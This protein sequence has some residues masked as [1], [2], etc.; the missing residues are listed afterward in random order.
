MTLNLVGR[1]EFK[2]L[3]D[4]AIKATAADNAFVSLSDRSG[5]TTRFANSQITQNVNVRRQSLSV[6]VAFGQ[7]HGS[8][9]TTQLSDAAIQETVRRA[10]AVAKIA[11]EDAEYL[12]P[13]PAQHYPVLPTLRLETAETGPA[14]RLRDAKTAIDLCRA[15]DLTAAGIVSTYTTATGLAANTGLFAHE[16]RSRAQFSLTATGKNSTGWVNNANRSID[17]LGVEQRTRNA[18]DKA[19]GSADPKEIP[20]GKYTV[21]ATFAPTS[22]LSNSRDSIL[23]RLDASGVSRYCGARHFGMANQDISI[24]SLPKL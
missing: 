23:P 4:L 13:L 14:R 9:S 8:A 11:P 19:R 3:A 16:T 17:D 5:G 24:G 10:E 21:N 1:D 6:S 20:A 22:S 7:R 12:P 2:R 15:A 18:I